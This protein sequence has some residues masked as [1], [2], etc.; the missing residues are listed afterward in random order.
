MDP[1]HD[2]AR[3]DKWVWGAKQNFQLNYRQ[4]SQEG[5]EILL[6]HFGEEASLSTNPW[7]DL[8]ISRR[9]FNSKAIEWKEGGADL[10]WCILSKY[11]SSF[12]QGWEKI[13]QKGYNKWDSSNFS[14]SFMWGVSKHKVYGLYGSKST[15]ICVEIRIYIKDFVVMRNSVGDY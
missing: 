10:Y 15:I 8:K 9:S 3:A 11:K 5:F 2:Q 4:M 12:I 7:L 6:K 14:M 1:E 13:G